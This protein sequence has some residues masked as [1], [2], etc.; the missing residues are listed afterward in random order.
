MKQMCEKGEIK[1]MESL[2]YLAGVI[3]VIVSLIM[4]SD[5]GFLATIYSAAPIVLMLFGMASIINRLDRHEKLIRD[6]QKNETTDIEEEY[7]ERENW[8]CNVCGRKNEYYID[9]C[10]CGQEKSNN[11]KIVKE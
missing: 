2:L 5:A 4:P 1:Y 6:L 11:K 3:V 8:K 7:G 10:G 9:I